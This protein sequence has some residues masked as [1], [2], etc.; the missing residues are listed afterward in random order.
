[1]YFLKGGFYACSAPFQPTVIFEYG[2]FAV[3]LTFRPE[4]QNLD[5]HQQKQPTYTN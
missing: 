3:L 4:H 5:I 1:V 2:I